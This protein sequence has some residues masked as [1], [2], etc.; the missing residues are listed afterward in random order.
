MG[1]G[2]T[3]VAVPGW[4][5]AGLPPKCPGLP[6]EPFHPS[7]S[8]HSPPGRAAA[9]RQMLTVGAGGQGRGLVAWPQLPAAGSSLPCKVGGW[10]CQGTRS[11]WPPRMSS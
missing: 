3:G 5:Q 6:A 9:P 1:S 7:G 2:G 10:G 8:A 4:R 11:P